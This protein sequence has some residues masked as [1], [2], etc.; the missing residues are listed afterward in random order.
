[1]KNIL[2]F[3]I[4]FLFSG[5]LHAQDSSAR[6]AIGKQ[7][8]ISTETNTKV[9][10]ANS[11]KAGRNAESVKAPELTTQQVSGDLNDKK[12]NSSAEKNTK[13]EPR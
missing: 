9:N 6:N 8:E 1:M 3:S 10:P 12:R 13:E 7:S 2:F 4:G 11:D 5:F